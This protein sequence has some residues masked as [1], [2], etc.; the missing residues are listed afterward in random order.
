MLTYFKIHSI[1]FSDKSLDFFSCKVC[2]QA[3]DTA[4]VS[5]SG[6]WVILPGS[7]LLNSH[8]PH[9]LLDLI[10]LSRSYCLKQKRFSFKEVA[11]ASYVLIYW[12]N[13][14]FWKRFC[15]PAAIVWYIDS[16]RKHCTG[17]EQQA[18]SL[19]QEHE[20]KTHALATNIHVLNLWVFCL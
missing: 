20:M 16:T 15:V 12:I 8:T 5:D 13:R 11:F 19:W 1:Y 3:K 4:T 10:H 2:I 14:S 9:H 18:G 7:A 6:L 17:L